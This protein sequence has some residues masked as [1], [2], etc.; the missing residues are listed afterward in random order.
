MTH[1]CKEIDNEEERRWV[2]TSV[3]HNKLEAMRHW[4]WTSVLLKISYLGIFAWCFKYG[5]TLTYMG[6]AYVIKQLKRASRA[7]A[8]APSSSS[9]ARPCS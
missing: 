1:F 2:L 8:S 3:A 6:L 7:A 9:S 4:E 5:T